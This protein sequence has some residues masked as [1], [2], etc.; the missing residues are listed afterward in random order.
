MVKHAA[1]E[2]SVLRDSVQRG[3]CA[4][5]LVGVVVVAIKADALG[6]EADV[7]DVVLLV[8]GRSSGVVVREALTA[9]SQRCNPFVG[10]PV[11]IPIGHIESRDASLVAPPRQSSNREVYHIIADLDVCWVTAGNV[12]R[13]QLP[14]RPVVCRAVQEHD[15]GIGVPA[16]SL[17]RS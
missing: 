14:C 16:A 8:A 2:D 1:G 13:A 15:I 9:L 10:N 17:V 5:E 4:H 7:Q 11:A 12:P 3:Y 6:V